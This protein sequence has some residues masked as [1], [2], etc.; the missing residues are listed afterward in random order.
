VQARRANVKP[1]A[2]RA[3]IKLILWMIFGLVYLILIVIFHDICVFF[4]SA[5][6]HL[7]NKNQFEETETS[8]IQSM[9]SVYNTEEIVRNVEITRNVDKFS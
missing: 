6:F 9:R 8:N 1:S 7:N 3:L 5:Y 2:T 4:K